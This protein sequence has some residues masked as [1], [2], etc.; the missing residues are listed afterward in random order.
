MAQRAGDLAIR[1]FDSYS[2]SVN[3]RERNRIESRRFSDSGIAALGT[4][5]LNRDIAEPSIEGQEISNKERALLLQEKVLQEQAFRN[6]LHMDGTSMVA[7]FQ[8]FAKRIGDAVASPFKTDAPIMA[9]MGMSRISPNQPRQGESSEDF[10]K[11]S[12]YMSRVAIEVPEVEDAYRGLT[13]MLS[14]LTVTIPTADGEARELPWQDGL[15][16]ARSDEE[17]GNYLIDQT[18]DEFK[19]YLAGLINRRIHRNQLLPKSQ[20][21]L[22]DNAKAHA[23]AMGADPDTYL[24]GILAREQRIGEVMR[25]NDLNSRDAAIN[26]L[27]IEDKKLL[28]DARSRA[29]LVAGGLKDDEVDLYMGAKDEVAR[30][31]SLREIMEAK[32]GAGA[33]E[34]E[35]DL[36]QYAIEMRDRLDIATMETEKEQLSVATEQAEALQRYQTEVAQA[37]GEKVAEN[38]DRSKAFNLNAFYNYG[39]GPTVF[40]QPLGTIGAP[41]RKALYHTVVDDDLGLVENSAQVLKV[42]IA[43]TGNVRELAFGDVPAEMEAIASEQRIAH[44]TRLVY[45]N[46]KRTVDANVA[47]FVLS[48]ITAV[49]DYTRTIQNA[50]PGGKGLNETEQKIV[51]EASG[52]FINAYKAGVGGDYALASKLH[53]DALRLISPRIHRTLKDL[54]LEKKEQTIRGMRDLPG[55]PELLNND[56]V[57]PEKSGADIIREFRA[58]GIDVPPGI[59]PNEVYAV[60]GKTLVP[61]K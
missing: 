1:A 52:A 31:E 14:G 58:V 7:R 5:G 38:I 35:S 2:T 59:K 12:A 26:I 6:K 28:D 4:L 24:D 32:Y 15:T 19:P 30:Q 51:A 13:S 60:D 21:E 23:I 36:K 48:P 37:R 27:G 56:R 29:V 44:A 17:T 61:K 22:Y 41:F 3:N 45:K 18:R 11:R 42:G 20:T 8:A 16:I 9:H 47:D 53:I 55:M 25:E 40:N 39:D 34:R 43:G 49:R 33:A 54:E 46:L 50:F 10:A 57:L